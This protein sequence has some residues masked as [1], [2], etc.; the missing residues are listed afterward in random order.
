MLFVGVILAL[1]LIPPSTKRLVE[2]AFSGNAD[3]RA[4]G[5]EALLAEDPD[6][7][8]HTLLETPRALVRLREKGSRAGVNPNALADVADAL[9]SIGRLDPETM[10]STAYVRYLKVELDRAGWSRA[11]C[12]AAAAAIAELPTDMPDDSADDTEREVAALALDLLRGR[13][14]GVAHAALLA[15]VTFAGSASP[16]TAQSIVAFASDLDDPATARDAWLLCGLLGLSDP[17]SD[18]VREGLPQSVADAVR[19]AVSRA[20]GAPDA[21]VEADPELAPLLTSLRVGRSV[22][23]TPPEAPTDPILEQAYWPGPRWRI[24]LRVESLGPGEARDAALELL[25][26]YDDHVRRA[27]LLACGLL[28]VASEEIALIEAADDDPLNRRYARLARLM[29]EQDDADEATRLTQAVVSMG[30]AGMVPVDDALFALLAAGRTEGLDWLF[31]P[32]RPRRSLDEPALAWDEAIRPRTPDGLWP[33]LTRFMD[34]VLDIPPNPTAGS[35]RATR[36]H[37]DAMRMWW[38][39]HRRHLAFDSRERVFRHAIRQ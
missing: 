27:G 19:F 24:A 2:R 7:P 33:M 12:L 21:V 37:S 35:P 23:V 16:G 39:I 31:D 9:R 25:G 1:L 20:G 22:G 8:G 4:A 29:I 11:A 34:P 38:L 17:N 13:D 26:E 6:R 10:G 5:I 18:V 15:F 28:S 14:A 32:L 36:L 3:A 30:S